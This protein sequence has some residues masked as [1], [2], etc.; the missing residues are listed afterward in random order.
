MRAG[1]G[2]G[3]VATGSFG[4]VPGLLL[5]PFLTDR[6]G[7]AAA[8][9]GLVVLLP[10]AWDVILNPI[11][12]GISDRSDHPGGRRRPYVIRAGTA[13][14]VLFFLLFAG[15]T[16]PTWLGASW[17]VLTFLAC[18]TAYAFFQVPYVAMPAELT[19]D[20][21]ERTRLMTWRVAILALAILV[22]GGL[23]PVIRDIGGATWGYRGVGLF[24]GLLIL[25][26]TYAAWR[27]TAGVPMREVPAPM[28]GFREQLRLV[29]AVRDFR[30]LLTTFVLQALA[31]GCM[32]A[33]VDYMARW[34]VGRS[35]AA[36]ILFVAFVAPALIVTPLWQVAG[37][38]LGKKRGYLLASAVLVIGALAIYLS[39]GR[40][41]AE[42]A[43]AVAVVGIGYA[44][45]QLFPLA[46]LPDVAARDAARSGSNRVGVFTGVW[47][48]A[49]TLGLALGPGLYAVVLA[50][51]GYASSAGIRVAQSERAIDAIHL[52]FSLIPAALI[53]LSVVPLAGYRLAEPTVVGDGPAPRTP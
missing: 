28:A 41:L 27:G 26:G 1:Y 17:V 13:L 16:A 18:A 50:W 2:L 49:E 21:S 37:A 53:A 39:R 11:A 20:P 10:K 47:T 14:A 32:L 29:S 7:L 24:V 19:D 12:G 3:S 46:M 25:F 30:L 51:G 43:L 48:G 22:S 52:G 34:V 31:T 40:S 35:G 42:V 8:L 33:G 44:G 5:L 45:A 9:A 4:T 23:A 6:I 36:T 38:Y 15:P